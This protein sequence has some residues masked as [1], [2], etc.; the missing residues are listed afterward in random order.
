MLAAP[1]VPTPKELAATKKALQKAAS[2]GVAP[3]VVAMVQVLLA[4]V[5]VWLLRR[6][7]SQTSPSS[8]GQT[9]GTRVPCRPPKVAG[10]FCNAPCNAQCNAF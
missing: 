5:G 6:A 3:G 2:A 8:G 1:L 10:A 4:G 7:F 9:S